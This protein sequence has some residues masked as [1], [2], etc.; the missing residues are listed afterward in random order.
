M[1]RFSWVRDEIIEREQLLLEEIAAFTESHPDLARKLLAFP[2]IGVNRGVTDAAPKGVAAIRL[3]ADI[4]FD[5]GAR[6]IESTWLQNGIFQCNKADALESNRNPRRR[7]PG[8]GGASGILRRIRER[9]RF[10][11]RRAGNYADFRDF[12]GVSGLWGRPWRPIPGSQTALPG[13]KRTG[14]P[15]FANC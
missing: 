10:A 9:F 4:D 11:T 12:Q 3:T 5:L 15:S 14:S 6:L 1:S 8:H 13:L 7:Q 2:W